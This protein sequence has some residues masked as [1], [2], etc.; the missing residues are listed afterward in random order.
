MES[1]EVLDRLPAHLL[2]LVIEQPYNEYTA[3]DHAVWRY[4]M[5]QNVHYL[6]KVAHGSY[7]EGLKKTGISIDSIPHMYGM[8]RILKEIGW[9]A[10]AVDGFI[11]PSAFMEFQAWNVLVIAA[12]IRPVT[13][14]GYTPAPDIVHE[15]A[16]HAP[17]IADPEYAAYLV[18][19]GKIGSRAFMSRQ[20][21]DLYE[22]I[23]L[24][25][26]L[27]ADPYTPVELI[28][29]AEQDLS[30]KER[31]MTGSSEL[32]QIRNLHWWTVEYGL[33]GDLRHPKIYGA[34]LLSSISE[35][36]NCLR[37]SVKKIPYSVDAAKVSFDITTEQPQLFVTPDFHALS[38]VL[39]EYASSMALRT[40]GTSGLE[41]AIDAGTV[42][43]AVYS[44]G[45]QVSGVISEFKK[46]GGEPAHIRFSP[47]VSLSY[48]DKQ[49]E[50][51]GKD[52]HAHGFSS[53]VGKLAGEPMPLEEMTDGQID[54]F[55]DKD[56]I[57]SFRFE[58][59]IEVKGVI[60]NILRKAGK[61]ILIS[62]SDCTVRMDGELLF[63]P[64]WG[65]YDMAVGAR[66]TSVYPGPADP[67]AWGLSYEAPKTRTHKIVHTPED[68]AL[69]ALYQ[70]VR[71][72]RSAGKG[73]GG[74]ER[75]WE[76]IRRE[77]PAEWLLP[78]E[79][80]ELA[81]RSEHPALHREVLEHL[82][83][84]KKDRGFAK[85]VDDGLNLLN[86]QIQP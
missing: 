59:G 39:E 54:G 55:K 43:T 34:G 23:R 75:A 25:S 40:G 3:Q 6:P 17:I 8:N 79:I 1:N 77:Y 72:F 85:L 27:K 36:Y 80:L 18:E 50:G 53:P 74:L 70:A 26:I 5:R 2:S 78:L 63:R 10:V 46:S 60:R 56:G 12:D 64:E 11:P 20:D 48:N 29:K 19:F 35:S 4:I 57:A 14:I 66:I 71:D 84:I 51:H 33:I 38:S 30:E 24:L 28:A 49:L 69:H 16:G 21:T 52:Y 32:A 62:F 68:L 7:I 31:S 82:S 58:S 45:L 81:S 76:K 9:A 44:S 86:I 61:I 42:A 15:A 65:V 73:N 41:K 67:A 22:A 83:S 47:A 37:E 13:Q